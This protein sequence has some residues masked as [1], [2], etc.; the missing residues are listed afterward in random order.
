MRRHLWASGPP[1]DALGRG[2]Q[3]QRQ[4][5]V[6]HH[7]PF[8][9][10][11]PDG[12]GRVRL[13]RH[14]LPA[15]RALHAGLGR[16]AGFRA[17]AARAHPRMERAAWLVASLL[18]PPLATAYEPGRPAARGLAAQGLR[19]R[20]WRRC[21]LVSARPIPGLGVAEGP[22]RTARRTLVSHTQDR[23]DHR[24]GR[25]PPTEEEPETVAASSAE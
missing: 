10:P 25:A 7:P 18:K 22:V 4:Q 1:A 23:T 15:V 24:S 3:L 8:A 9:A 13:L 11:D 6:S 17:R 14:V 2:S 5:V 20:P 12:K 19:R 21:P 16:L